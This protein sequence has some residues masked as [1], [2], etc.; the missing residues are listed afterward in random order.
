MF[1]HSTINT[2][3]AIPTEEEALKVDL[4]LYDA[5]L[6]LKDK[7]VDQ[8]KTHLLL[9]VGQENPAEYFKQ[10]ETKFKALSKEKAMP[11]HYRS[12]KSVLLSCEKYGIDIVTPEGFPR[13]K[14]E[15]EKA[16]KEA[17]DEKSP[18]VKCM[19]TLERLHS[20][21][22]NLDK[23]ELTALH[24]AIGSMF[25]GILADNIVNVKA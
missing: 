24:K 19:D 11:G 15:L 20:Q 8:F 3:V 22:E 23:A 9:V 5:G 2:S 25:P 14:T 13:G 21:S 17:K 16:I 12:N 10:Y 1:K 6:A 4:M 7:G 18:M